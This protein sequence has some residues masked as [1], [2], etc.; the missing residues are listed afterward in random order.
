MQAKTL[1]PASA[2]FELRS[3]CTVTDPE[4]FH[5]ALVETAEA[6]PKN[7]RAKLG[8]I[9]GDLRDYLALRKATS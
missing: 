1:G 3:G 9:Q 5:K 2:P 4:L 8:A 6:G 7:A